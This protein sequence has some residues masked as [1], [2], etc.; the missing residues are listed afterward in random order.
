MPLLGEMCFVLDTHLGRLARYLRMLG[1]D[2]LYRNDYDDDELAE[3]SAAEG[4]ILLTRDR[5]ILKRNEV[6]YGYCLRS[7][8]PRKQLEEILTRFDLES[9]IH[10][11]SRCMHCNHMLQSTTKEKISQHVP[12]RIAV[13]IDHF[14]ICPGCK[15]VYWK[16]SHHAKMQR[17][18]TRVL[19]ASGY[20]LALSQVNIELE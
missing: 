2:S 10:P 16:G 1:L 4:R 7:V 8:Q 9:W 12:E 5:G 13:E 14:M 6:V 11:F 19:K 3:I 18:I 20:Q 15:R 17:L